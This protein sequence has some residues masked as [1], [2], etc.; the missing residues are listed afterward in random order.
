MFLYPRTKED[1]GNDPWR[2]NP[3][4]NG[5]LEAS[6]ELSV[7]Q[8][9]GNPSNHL[10]LWGWETVVPGLL[11]CAWLAVNVLILSPPQVEL[12]QTQ[13]QATA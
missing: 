10:G 6:L 13:G 11:A 8:A 1:T 7:P 2:R 4:P 3:W 9:A 5:T 12:G